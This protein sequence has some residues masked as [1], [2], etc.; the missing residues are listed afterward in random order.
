MAFE[1]KPEDT[2]AAVSINGYAIENVESFFVY[3]RSEITWNNERSKVIDRM[4]QLA[5]AAKAGMVHSVIG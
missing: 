3:L 4:I 5:T 1:K 2:D